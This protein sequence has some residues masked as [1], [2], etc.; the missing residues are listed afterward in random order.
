[1]LFFGPDWSSGRST[2]RWS[3]CEMTRTAKPDIDLWYRRMLYGHVR[4]YTCSTGE[5]AVTQRS[6]HSCESRCV[7]PGYISGCLLPISTQ[8][9]LWRVKSIVSKSGFC[10]F[11]SSSVVWIEAR[12]PAGSVLRRG[13][14]SPMS[15]KEL[16]WVIQHRGW[17]Y[18]VHPELRT[19]QQNRFSPTSAIFSENADVDFDEN[20]LIGSN[21]EKKSPRCKKNHWNRFTEL[22]ELSWA[23]RMRS[24]GGSP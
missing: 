16:W 8:T 23:N 19:A 22:W 11:S 17:S 1:M 21:F 5:F 12:W 18:G 4:F 7:L 10:W 24:G 13:N 15:K 14:R 20:G 9:N 2:N 3:T 6:F